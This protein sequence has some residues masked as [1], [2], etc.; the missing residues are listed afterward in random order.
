VITPDALAHAAHEVGE[1]TLLARAGGAPTLAVG[2]SHILANALGG[3]AMRAF[4]Y[5]FAILFEALF[6]LTAVDAGTRAGRFMLQDLLGTFVPMMRNTR[7]WSASLLATG[8]C[9]A[10]WGYFLYQGVVDP[11]GGINT[12]WPL[13]GISNQMLAAVA[14]TLATVV[15]FKMKRQRYAWVTILP[16]SWLLICTL[17]AG[18]QKMFDS[19]PKIGFLAHAAI[20]RA[21]IADGRILAPAKSMDQMSQIVVNDTVDAALAGLFI[22]VVASMAVLGVRAC[23]R[24]WQTNQPTAVE[25]TPAGAAVRA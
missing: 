16:T 5:H 24:G 13:F 12:L 15:L 21:A 14:L 25:T 6:I 8:L 9:V 20:Y 18:W 1:N 4:W 23:W 10:F 2:M 11:L 22:A 17:T 19:N 7:S 3:D